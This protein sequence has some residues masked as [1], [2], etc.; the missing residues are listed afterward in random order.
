MRTTI[1]WA[2]HPDDETLYL[3]GY[4]GVCRKRGDQLI[5]VAVTDGGASGAKPSSWT[6]EDMMRVRREEQN[7]AWRSL[8]G[9]DAPVIRMG[10]PDGGIDADRVMNLAASLEKIYLNDAPV[11]HYVGGST[12]STQSPDHLA[13]AYGVKNAGV[14]ICRG[15]KMPSDTTSGGSVY[16]PPNIT[17]AKNAH[18]SY[19]AFGHK[20][21]SS[22]F[23]L[24][25]SSGYK[26]RIIG[27]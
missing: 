20:S 24:L 12:Q 9:A 18:D 11:E 10:L 21:V 13:V 27:L 3:A 8:A 2:P 25:K 7:R 14:A 23:A 19:L 22:Q 26:S 17:D 1:I 4:I 5:L 6:V 16:F 15:S